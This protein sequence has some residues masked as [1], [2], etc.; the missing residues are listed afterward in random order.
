MGAGGIIVIKNS[1][2]KLRAEAKA[3][4]EQAHGWLGRKWIEICAVFGWHK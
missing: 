2:A 4:T 1:A 3:M